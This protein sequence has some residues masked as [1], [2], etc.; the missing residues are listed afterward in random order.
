MPRIRIDGHRQLRGF[1][2]ISGAKNAVLKLMAAALM[3]SGESVIHNVP[4]IQDVVTM[5]ELLG[6][7][8]VGVEF[9]ANTLRLSVGEEIGEEAPHEL[10]RKMRA[11]IQVMGPLLGRLGRVRVSLPGGCAI[12]ERPIDFHLKGLRQLGAKIW[13]EHGYIYAETD[14]LKG[15]DIQL[16]YPSVGATENLMMAATLA[17]GTT[18]IRNAAREPEIIETQNF[19]NQMGAR[20]RGAGTDVIRI[21]GVEGLHPAEH[22]TIPDRI[23]VGTYLVAAAMA[24]GKV[25]LHSVIPQHVASLIAK[26]RETGVDI[27]VDEDR[28]TVHSN[29]RYRAVNFQSLPYP[30]FPTD[31]LPQVMAMMA[32][33]EGT[34][35]IRETVYTNRYK[36][37]GELVRMGANIIVAD[38]T[39]VVQGVVHLTGA[40]V[41]VPDLRA[42]AA[43]VLAALVADGTTI[44]DDDDG[45]LGRGYDDLVGKLQAVGADMFY[46]D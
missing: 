24:G 23:E 30:G 32:L 26:L 22:T 10:V 9:N 42:G 14:R 41:L 38:R 43:L 45:H 36:H 31:L 39:A 27:A 33:A 20:I 18:Q 25:T 34:S 8:G 21:D 28:V 44:I 15:V 40:E 17:Q 35:V 4:H 2:P 19:L 12:G 5:I 6:T 7:L 13:E 11:S 16:D 3:A 29:G 46:V 37:V 1:I